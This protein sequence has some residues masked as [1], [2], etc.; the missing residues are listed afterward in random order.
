MVDIDSPLMQ[1]S[2]SSEK[3]FYIAVD[4]GTTYSAVSFVALAPDED[5]E[6]VSPDRIKSIVNYPKD[7]RVYGQ[8]AKEVPTELS[9]LK[10]AKQRNGFNEDEE[11]MQPWRSSAAQ[12]DY[13]EYDED[14]DDAPP[15]EDDDFDD[16]TPSEDPQWGYMVQDTLGRPN[17]ASLAELKKGCLRRAKLLLDH[18]EHTK[19]AREELLGAIQ[20]VKGM[21]KIKKNED[22]IIHFLT[23]LFRHVKHELETNHGYTDQCAVEFILCVPPIWSSKASRTMHDAMATA[24]RESGF[25]SRASKCVDNLFIV[26]EPEAAATFILTTS[27]DNHKI[28]ANDTFVLLDA[29]GGTVDAITYSVQGRAR[30]VRLKKEEVMA[31]GRLCGSSF[32]NERFKEH[33]KERLKDELYLETGNE[34][35]DQ[36]I[37]SEAIM[38]NFEHKFKRQ[39][40]FRNRI[41]ADQRF[42]IRALRENR[43]KNLSR[44]AFEVNSDDFWKIFLPSLQGVASLMESQLDL[45]REARNGPLNVEKVIVIGGFAQSPALRD[46]LQKKLKKINE[47]HKSRVE[48]IA[49][50]VRDGPGV[51]VASGAVLRALNKRSGPERIMRSSY[52]ILCKEIYDEDLPG[53]KEA[54]RL[55]LDIDGEEYVKD[56]MVWLIKKGITIFSDPERRQF[57]LPMTKIISLKAGESF[58]CTQTLY[59]SDISTESHYQKYHPKNR[60]K[61]EIAGKIKADMTF[62][63]RQ[64]LIQPTIPD[65]GSGRPHYKVE[66]EILFEVID[67]NLYYKAVWPI[68]N[69]E[70]VIPGSEGWTNIAAAFPPGTN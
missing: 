20:H 13:S 61:H 12:N 57:R 32:I 23:N 35:I 44:G 16:P 6:E 69:D 36:I 15:Y 68:G 22:I 34:S 37:E 63:K 33:V 54:K 70:G 19:S 9:Y 27:E 60:G 47:K 56:S 58:V 26:S 39:M 8:T 14:S 55:E 7:P 48:L 51:A 24:L 50:S 3:R 21:R 53:H 5:A 40:N 17:E 11:R 10:H 65:S 2:P 45:A 64:N 4:Y 28:R 42:Y 31:D 66:F 38:G 67:R 49:P 25:I 59:V 46:Y 52:G 1:A 29:G 18:S 30:D 41:L 43:E 62:L